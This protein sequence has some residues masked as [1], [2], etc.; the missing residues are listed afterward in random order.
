MKVTKNLFVVDLDN[1]QTRVI[2][3]SHEKAILVD[4]WAEWCAPCRVIAPVLEKIAAEFQD[5]LDIAK[6][7]VDEGE[8]MKIAGQYQVRGFPTLILFINGQEVDRFSG[9]K[10]FHFIQTFIEQHIH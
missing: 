9:A 10:P 7:E 8:N 1:F 4:L 6:L 2:A 5:T 3:A